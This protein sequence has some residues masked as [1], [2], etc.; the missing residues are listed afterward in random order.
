MK[1]V[2]RSKR[3]F[4]PL[5]E[6]RRV[7]EM[8]PIKGDHLHARADYTIEEA[9]RQWP[10]LDGHLTSSYLDRKGRSHFSNAPITHQERIWIIVSKPQL[11]GFRRGLIC[12]CGDDERRIEIVPQ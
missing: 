6:A 11:N 12:Y 8:L 3:K 9:D 1:C 7:T 2:T 4:V 5:N 10:A